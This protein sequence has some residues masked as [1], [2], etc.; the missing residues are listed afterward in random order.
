MTIEQE[1][2]CHKE[3]NREI[4]R[5]KIVVCEGL[6]EER[7]LPRLLENCNALRLSQDLQFFNCEGKTKLKSFLLS[8][9]SFT[10]FYQVTSIGIVIDA[11]REPKGVEPSF[12]KAQN[13][14]KSIKFPIPSSLGQPVE[15]DG[16][17]AG[18]WIMPDNQSNG[19]L[20]D[21][22]LEAAKQHSL[23]PCV[24]QLED[25]ILKTGWPPSKSA[26][27]PLYTLLAWLDPPGRRLA[28][29]DDSDILCLNLE[30]FSPFLKFLSEL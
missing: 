25:C 20:E 26:K 29:L 14:L 9:T 12:K 24:K 27:S 19:E 13:A 28:E 8:F 16:K 1:S 17:K 5:P 30:V 23:M 6:E 21:L 18:I 2:Q 11:N 7:F 22:C 3:R 10:G 15:S 4:E